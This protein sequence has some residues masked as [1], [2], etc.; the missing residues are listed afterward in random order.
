MRHE[1]IKTYAINVGTDGI[2]MNYK[3]INSLIKENL[4][5]G[6]LPFLSERIF[7]PDMNVI[8]GKGTPDINLEKI[9]LK[10]ASIGSHST[11]W[12]YG[13]D[14]EYLGLELKSSSPTEY[15]EAVKKNT[16][17][18]C[19]PVVIQ[20]VRERFSDRNM[21][22]NTNVL[23][24]G[25]CRDAQCAYL[26]DQFTEKSIEKVFNLSRLEKKLG[27]GLNAKS[28]LARK[29]I[30]NRIEY[31]TGKKASEHTKAAKANLVANMKKNSSV[32]QEIV[33]KRNADFKNYLPEQKAVYDFCYKH[34]LEQETGERLYSFTESDRA[35]IAQSFE[36]LLE[37][38]EENPKISG[39][40]ARTIFDAY[41]FS[42]RLIHRNF[43][44][45]P[46]FTKEDELNRKHNTARKLPDAL[47]RQENILSIIDENAR[48]KYRSRSFSM[49]VGEEIGM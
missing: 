14:A 2:D 37:K 12:I 47:T 43:S 4:F 19:R 17:F 10:A 15:R 38:I 8:T 13:A 31:N 40:I 35:G 23:S 29:I 26:L 33:N 24:E 39:I 7:P 27:G 21:R 32:F 48:E 42:Q 3:E 30:E 22:G 9:L 5:H 36:T 20:K 41:S 6:T 18:N 45:E 46:I 11:M 49:H 1:E 34:F 25:L 44:L 16:N 28:F